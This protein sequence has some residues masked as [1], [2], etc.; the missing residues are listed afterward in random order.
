[1]HMIQQIIISELTCANMTFVWVVVPVV[2]PTVVPAV[3][4]GGVVLQCC[5]W[6][7]RE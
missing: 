5:A 7:K 1:M 3:V 6:G 2:V 4:P